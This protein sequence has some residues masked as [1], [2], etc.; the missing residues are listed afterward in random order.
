V[1]SNALLVVAFNT[2]EGWSGDVS[3]EIAG[4]VADRARVADDAL[5]EDTKRLID[6]HVKPPSA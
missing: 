5:S 3:E 2:A 1:Y 6:R 4:E